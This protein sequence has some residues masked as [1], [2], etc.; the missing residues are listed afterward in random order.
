MVLER[1][2]AC[3]HAAAAK[4]QSKRWMAVWNEEL[5]A[6]GRSGVWGSR[7]CAETMCG[8]V[9]GEHERAYSGSWKQTSYLLSAAC[10]AERESWA[11]SSAKRPWPGAQVVKWSREGCLA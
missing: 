3:Q 5:E 7:D 6:G 10:G 4:C 11:S 2:R 8:P 1:F 9:G